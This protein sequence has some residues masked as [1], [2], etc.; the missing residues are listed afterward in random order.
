MLFVAL[1]ALP[2]P[3]ADVLICYSSGYEPDVVAKI[4]ATG[5]FAVVDEFNCG[6]GTPT[7]AQ[8]ASYD[9][10]LVYSDSGFIDPTL[11]GDRL[12]TFVDGGGG[13]VEA[14][15]ASGSVP[16]SGRFES[17]G[18]EA[19]TGSAQSQGAVLNMV[20][21]DP[22]H[23]I[24]AGVVDFNAGT[25][26]YHTS[27]ATLQVGGTLIA[28]YG[29]NGLP[30]VATLETH[31][32]RT[33]GLNFYPPSS[34]IRADFWDVATDGDLLLANSLEWAGDL[35][36]DG[37]GINDTFD[38]CPGIAN[39]TQD[40]GDLDGLG[41]VCDPCDDFVD[42]DTDGDGVCDS[43][44]VCPG[45]SDV[46]DADADGVM[47]GCDVCPFDAPDQDFDNDGVCNFDDVC[48]NGSDVDD[49]DGD[50][51]ADGCDDCPAGNDADADQVCD[52]F[53]RCPGFDDNADAD[54]DAV[55]D[56]CDACPADAPDDDLDDDGTC[57]RDDVCPGFDDA[58][59][60]DAD[61]QPDGCDPCPIWPLNDEDGDGVCGDVDACPGFN[62]NLDADA[63]GLA[64]GCD[65]CPADP[66]GADDDDLDS[67][68]NSVDACPGFDDAFDQDA[69]RRP[70]ACDNCPAAA[71]PTQT[72]ADGDTFGA[73]CDCDDALPSVSPDADEVCDGFD[74]DCDQ[75]VDEAGAVGEGTWFADRDED[76]QGDPDAELTGC[77]RPPKASTNA[78]D[79]DDSDPAVFLGA[80]E[81]CDDIDNDCN[82]EIDELQE[83]VAAP[84]DPDGSNDPG[85]CGCDS[86]PSA[87]PPAG[88]ALLALVG[89]RR[90]R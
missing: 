55:P 24:L 80:G 77:D 71:N 40:D 50:G 85:G 62:D 53:D 41:D 42:P 31:P 13:V 10:V 66:A 2:A 36:L 52:P 38:N 88:L 37:D 16:V 63:D 3:A 8:L 23:P 34:T 74:N 48:P 33:V 44:D 54:A 18:Y 87:L 26:S 17:Q 29:Q 14:V 83:C 84:P 43:T 82:G 6:A 32:G 46:L 76:G 9:S 15:F 56:G 30:L 45:G 4:Q 73:S 78:D 39:P 12:A 19:F 61:S 51:I 5:R 58:V 11:L 69:D 27:N 25:A 47:D 28:H 67:I 49:T 70:D 89:L 57:N 59:N 86:A 1:L 22:T 65:A 20:I 21:D 72:D 75:E 7:D 79:C 64:N 35:D 60:A 81:L 90:R 68:C